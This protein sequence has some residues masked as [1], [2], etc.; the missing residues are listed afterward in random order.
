MLSADLPPSFQ[1]SDL[2]PLEP[3]VS[4]GTRA[5]TH[6]PLTYVCAVFTEACKLQ[7]VVPAVI[8][9]NADHYGMPNPTRTQPCGATC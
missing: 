8:R 9:L 1:C 3:G 6:I 4:R 2:Q 7:H 5:V